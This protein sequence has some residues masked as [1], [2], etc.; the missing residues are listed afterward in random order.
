LAKR[1]RLRRRGCYVRLLWV[2]AL[3]NACRPLNGNVADTCRKSLSHWP[4]SPIKSPAMRLE[5]SRSPFLSGFL[6]KPAQMT[7]LTPELDSFPT[8]SYYC[9]RHRSQK[10]LF[11]SLTVTYKL[12]YVPKVFR[13]VG[14][15][16][17]G[18]TRSS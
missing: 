15:F 10:V 4:S 3:A 7:A 12:M 18:I 6:L 8:S 16:P 2:K 17:T 5:S 11:K 9:Q 14:C 1:S 13:R